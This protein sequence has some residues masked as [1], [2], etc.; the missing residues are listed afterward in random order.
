LA[1]GFLGFGNMI[2]IGGQPESSTPREPLAIQIVESYSAADRDDL[3]GGE[4]DPS[5][6]SSY[7]LQWRPTEKHVFVVEAGNRICHV[8]IVQ[9]IVEVQGTPVRVAGIGGVLARP[10]YRGRGYCRVAMEAA[11]A[12]ALSQMHVHFMLLFCRPALQSFYEHLGWVKVAR[13]VW[14]EQVQGS[15]VLPLVSMVKRLGAGQWPQGE[16]RLGSRPW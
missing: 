2:E 1:H 8:G 14:G 13:P 7:Q 6:T 9:Q 4:K 15:V 16:V 3:A 11:E 5:Q 10:E 12:F